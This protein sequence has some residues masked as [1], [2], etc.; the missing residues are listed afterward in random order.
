MHNPKLQKK[1]KTR[2]KVDFDRTPLKDRL[3]A[4]F[5]NWAF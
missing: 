4:K 2:I 3:K 1:P 5:G